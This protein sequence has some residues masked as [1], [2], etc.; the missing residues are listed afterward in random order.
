LPWF[1]PVTVALLH[2]VGLSPSPSGL[3]GVSGLREARP[4]ICRRDSCGHRDLE[5]SHQVIEPLFDNLEGVNVTVRNVSFMAL[6]RAPSAGIFGS[7]SSTPALSAGVCR[8][9]GLWSRLRNGKTHRHVADQPRPAD[10]ADAVFR[11]TTRHRASARGT[12]PGAGTRGRSPPPHWADPP[13]SLTFGTKR[14]RKKHDRIMRFRPAQDAARGCTAA[15]RQN[16]I[17][18]PKSSPRKG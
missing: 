13:A 3:L 2:L 14:A 10:G 5:R 8:Q 15:N 9:V 11:L 6:K 16:R 7:A 17:K 18:R 1:W 12:D 4:R